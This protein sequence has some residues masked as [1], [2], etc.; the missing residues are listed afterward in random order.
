METSLIEK[1]NLRF[2]KS[3]ST[4]ILNYFIKE[5]MNNLALSTSLGAEDQVLTHMICN[6][7]K[8]VRIF[9]LDTGRLFPE[10]Y[11][12]I[13]KTNKKYKI[14][15]DIFFPDNNKVQE[16]VGKKGIN[17]FYDSIGNRKECCHVRKIEPLKR[18]LTGLKV[19]ITGLRKDQSVSRFYSK[20]VEWDDNHGLIKLNP[21]IN[22]TEKQVWD[23]IHENNIPY[24]PLHDKGFTSI[25]CQ[26]CTR[27]I[28]PGEDERAGRWWWEQSENKECGIHIK[29]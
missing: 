15:I 23:F 12:L 29:K 9:T 18:A 5:Y 8:S 19:W 10:T 7:D 20:L 3:D 21:L 27:A 24:S 1:L 14:N 25:G 22:L 4:D 13:D 6:I 26:P 17:L 11:D 2:E 28:Q 16:M